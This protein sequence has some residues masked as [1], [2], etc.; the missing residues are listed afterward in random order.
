MADTQTIPEAFLEIVDLSGDCLQAVQVT[1]V[2]FLIGR[3]RGN[4]LMLDDV[5]ISRRCA[6]V[7]YEKEGFH[8]H[9]QGQ[10]HGVFVDGERVDTRALRDG[11]CI[12]LGAAYPFR[13]VFHLGHPPAILLSDG[14]FT[15]ETSEVKTDTVLGHE[16][17]IAHDIQ[18]GL[19]PRSFHQFRH[20]EACGINRPCLAV[21][22][23]YFDLIEI[24]QDRAAF[25]IADVS[26]KGLG[27][28]LVASMLQGALLTMTLEQDLARVFGRINRFM[29]SHYQDHFAT[30]F[31]GIL[32]T[33]GGLELLNAGH[34]PPLRAHANRVERC[35]QA[36]CLPLG[37][38]ADADFKASSHNLKPGE[39][40]VFFTDGISEAENPEGEQYGLTRLQQVAAKYADARM[41][42]LQRALLAS[43]RDFTHGAYPVDDITLLIIRYKGK[44]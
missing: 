28:A 5:R 10:R 31:F 20:V 1:K 43:V 6:A 4:D 36:G 39:T 21:G 9:D 14:Q 17:A 23:D 25:V 42:E 35:F 18:Q 27:A 8:L 24:S 3:A 32:D 44:P 11:D 15:R 7:V 26:G 34:P 40:L 38:L 12:V 37:L 19:L 41:E 16:L 22:G 30:L 13:L 29:C 2:P 33:D